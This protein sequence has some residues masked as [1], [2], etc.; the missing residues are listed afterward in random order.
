MDLFSK[1]V[2]IPWKE[3]KLGAVTDGTVMPV[4]QVKDEVFAGKMMGD[5][6]GFISTSGIV[7]APCDGKVV[8]LFPTFHAIGIESL[9]GAQLLIHI[10]IDTVREQGKGFKAYIK[11]GDTV[12]RGQKLVSFDKKKLEAKGYD[13]TIPVI[14]TNMDNLEHMKIIK[15]GKVTLKEEVID[16]KIQ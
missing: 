9:D 13:L 5:G 3:G 6:V 8:T 1:K 15:E 14:F 12:K 7:F 16:Y 10:G 2:T 11:E 4:N